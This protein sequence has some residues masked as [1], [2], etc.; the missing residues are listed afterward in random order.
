MSNPQAEKTLGDILRSLYKKISWLINGVFIGLI[1]GGLVDR[2]LTTLVIGASV[3][4][5]LAVIIKLISWVRQ[6]SLRM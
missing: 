1:V 2:S 5:G 4:A 3:G 6:R